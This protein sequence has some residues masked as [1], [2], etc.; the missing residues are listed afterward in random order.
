ME[1]TDGRTAT[2][3]SMLRRQWL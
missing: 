2:V 1:E 3:L